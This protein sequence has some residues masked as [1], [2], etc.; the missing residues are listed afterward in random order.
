MR[1]EQ[2]S[3][4]VLNWKSL[5]PKR[6]HAAKQVWVAVIT[7]WVASALPPLLASCL[8][9]PPRYRSNEDWYKMRE[10]GRGVTLYSGPVSPPSLVLASLLRF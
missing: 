1:Y 8:T 5:R 4:E 7:N 3:V 10:R 9:Y 6:A 2:G